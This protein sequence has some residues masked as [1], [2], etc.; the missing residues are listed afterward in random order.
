MTWGDFGC[1]IAWTPEIEECVALYAELKT[2]PRCASGGPLHIITD[3]DNLDDHWLQVEHDRYFRHRWN[4]F[5]WEVVPVFDWPPEVIRICDRILELLREM[6]E[7]ER[8]AVN[9]YHWGY[10]QKYIKARAKELE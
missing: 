9:A 8:Y 2:H 5:K 4:G 6:M 7:A 3:D 10:A 1:P